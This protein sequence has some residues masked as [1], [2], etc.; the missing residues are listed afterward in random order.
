MSA[1]LS[2]YKTALS[3]W[4]VYVLLHVKQE[5]IEKEY[6]EECAMIDA[7]I[8]W[9]N[10]FLGKGHELPKEISEGWQTKYVESFREVGFLGSLAISNFWGYVEECKEFL[11][12]DL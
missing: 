8:D 12:Q 3:R 4:G 5:F 11:I 10:G 1:K 9:M 6:Y 7:A 2:K